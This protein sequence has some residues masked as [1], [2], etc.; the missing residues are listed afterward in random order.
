VAPIWFDESDRKM[1][2]GFRIANAFQGWVGYGQEDGDG[3]SKPVN[4]CAQN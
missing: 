1:C 3:K 4:G 2:V